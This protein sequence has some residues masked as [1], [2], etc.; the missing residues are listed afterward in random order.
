[1]Q[2]EGNNNTGNKSLN[3][4]L[5]DE[6][7]SSHCMDDDEDDEEINVDDT[8]F[9]WSTLPVISSQPCSTIPFFF[10]LKSRNIN[11]EKCAHAKKTEN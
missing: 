8:Q 5:S 10:K 1:M 9:N 11:T 7:D 2:Q 3:R 6:D 4:S